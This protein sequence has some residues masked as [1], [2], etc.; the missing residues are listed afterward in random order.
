MAKIS[1]NIETMLFYYVMI[2]LLPLCSSHKM[3]SDTWGKKN[4]IQ[5]DHPLS[6]I[7]VNVYTEGFSMLVETVVP[8]PERVEIKVF[9]DEFL[10][11]RN[12]ILF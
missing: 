4:L 12:E 9:T 11:T 7:V 1:I 2:F 3:S 8:L 10:A 5:E 6:Q